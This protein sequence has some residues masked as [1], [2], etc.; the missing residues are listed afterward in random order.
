MKKHFTWI[1]GC[2]IYCMIAS[3][4]FTILRLHGYYYYDDR[5]YPVAIPMML[6]L[7]IFV[8]WLNH[9]FFT[10]SRIYTLKLEKSPGASWMLIL[11]PA[12]L[13]L[14]FFE[15]ILFHTFDIKI[16]IIALLTF[17]IG[18]CEEGF[19]RGFLINYL[20]KITSSKLVMLIISSVCFGL[21]HMVNVTSGLSLEGAWIQSLGAIPFG[22]VAGLIYIEKRNLCVLILWHMYNDFS[23]FLGTEPMYF[24]VII[25]GFIVDLLFMIETAKVLFI[26]AKKLWIWFIQ[27]KQLTKQS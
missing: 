10:L 15:N 20:E 9:K 13:I 25:S 5:I 12:I 4:G 27:K 7:A 16:W 2:L 26:Y 19:F 22:V 14:L 8:L 24:S 21:L 6:V 17:L 11:M 23:L 1:L 18:F 3:V